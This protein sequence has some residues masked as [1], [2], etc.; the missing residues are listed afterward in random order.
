MILVEEKKVQKTVKKVN[1][2]IYIN[3]LVPEFNY[4]NGAGQTVKPQKCCIN[5]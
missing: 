1:N 5:L 2:K 3:T 4:T